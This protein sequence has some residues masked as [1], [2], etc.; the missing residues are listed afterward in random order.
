MP[1]IVEYFGKDLKPK[2]RRCNG[3]YVFLPIIFLW[4]CQAKHHVQQIEFIVG[5][6]WWGNI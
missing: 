1:K 3:R 6:A 2:L 5:I 4:A